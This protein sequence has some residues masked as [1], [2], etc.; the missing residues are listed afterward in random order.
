MEN[1]TLKLHSMTK[2]KETMSLTSIK[3]VNF[4]NKIGLR[5]LRSVCM[6]KLKIQRKLIYLYK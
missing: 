4:A 2:V 5:H 6:W 3:N 1:N